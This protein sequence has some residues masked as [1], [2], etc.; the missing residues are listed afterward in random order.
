M[1][2]GTAILMSHRLRKD[3]PRART[4]ARA[5]RRKANHGETN[6]KRKAL[7]SVPLIQTVAEVGIIGNRE[8]GVKA[9]GE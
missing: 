6:P 3:N 1:I 4:R 8:A 2:P 5:P 9:D 7:K